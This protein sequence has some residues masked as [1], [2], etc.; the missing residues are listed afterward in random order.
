MK[1]AVW[2]KYSSYTKREE[3]LDVLK[4]LLLGCYALTPKVFLHWSRLKLPRKSS[5]LFPASANATRLVGNVCGIKDGSW[6]KSTSTLSLCG[7]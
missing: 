5:S 7:C 1:Q 3:S 2:Q 6:G 4:L